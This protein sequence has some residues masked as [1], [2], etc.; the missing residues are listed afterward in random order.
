MNAETLQAIIANPATKPTDRQ[1]AIAALRAVSQGD[2]MIPESKP[3]SVMDGLEAEILRGTGA[4][5]LAGVSLDGLHQFRRE[6]GS[7]PDMERLYDKAIRSGAI[8]SWQQY[9]D[10]PDD[11][12]RF[13]E[14]MFASYN[15]MPSREAALR[16][17]SILEAE[18][19]EA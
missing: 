10:D 17:M 1:A 14:I 8:R 6:H 16:I 18:G 7:N 2:A 4:S 12:P 19:S 5:S 13:Y 11:N 15:E 3:A 9:V